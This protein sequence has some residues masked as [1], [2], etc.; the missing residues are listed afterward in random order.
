MIRCYECK[1]YNETR[2][3]SGWCEDP[4]LPK[5]IRTDA[6]DYCDDGEKIEVVKQCPN[7]THS[8][9]VSVCGVTLS[10]HPQ[11]AHRSI[12]LIVKGSRGEM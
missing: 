1:H 7:L 11:G 10:I 3:H 4:K 9:R 5:R 12:V 6:V 8:P 2:H